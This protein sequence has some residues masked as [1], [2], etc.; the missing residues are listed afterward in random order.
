[1]DKKLFKVN[2]Y[3]LIAAAALMILS[4]LIPYPWRLVWIPALALGIIGIV[5]LLKWLNE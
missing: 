3:L 5:R 1:M 4:C 2:I